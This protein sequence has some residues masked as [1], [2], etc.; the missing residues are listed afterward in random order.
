MLDLDKLFKTIADEAPSGEDLEYDAD[1]IEL[2]TANQPGEERMIGESV[3]PAADPDYDQV[4][5]L[6]TALLDRTKDL[7][8]AVTLANAALRTQGLPAFE[9]VLRYIRDCLENFWDSVHPQ[10]DEE[11]DDDPTMRV[12]AVLGLTNRTTVLRSLR[13]APLTNS[14]AFG[15]FCL[16]DLEIAAGEITPGSEIENVP[17]AQNISAAFQDQG[18]D[19]LTE[20]M[21][22]IV[23]LQDH[24]KAILAIF[25][26]KLG[27]LGPDLTPLLKM[28]HDIKQHL[29]KYTDNTLAED[30]DVAP[31]VYT[32]APKAT[33]NL[34]G[35]GAIN[36]PKDVV[37]AID[38]IVDYYARNEPSSPLPLLLTRAKKLVSADFFTIMKDMAPLGVENVAL[39]GGLDEDED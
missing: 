26:D 12:N 17:S 23:A 33:P 32:A 30:D 10:L 9:Q 27:A 36:C 35:I 15:R 21:A 5:D 37:N 18:A 1:F 25:D 22:A 4:I 20:T 39:I 19:N 8:I 14:R 34:Q 28:L 16:R 2:E 31:N 3:I 38:R 7:R 29:A 13:M 6:A 11:D 24:A